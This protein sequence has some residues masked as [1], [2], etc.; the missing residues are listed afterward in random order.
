MTVKNRALLCVI[1]GTAFLALGGTFAGAEDNSTPR[2]KLIFAERFRFE[3]WDNAINLDDA[4][5]ENFAYTRNK[6]T[7][8]LQCF[9][10]RGLEFSGKLTNE[11]CVYFAPKDAA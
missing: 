6:T 2:L 7:L 9:A 5:P 1:A 3:T 8:G 4:S 10:A 11:F